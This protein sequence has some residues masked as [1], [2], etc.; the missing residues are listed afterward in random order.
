MQYYCGGENANCKETVG[1][2]PRKVKSLSY[3]C[4]CLVRFY[5]VAVRGNRKIDWTKVDYLS[6]VDFVN[7]GRYIIP[8]SKLTDEDKAF[9]SKSGVFRTTYTSV[10]QYILSRWMA[11]RTKQW[12]YRF[13]CNLSENTTQA[14][15]LVIPSACIVEIQ[16]F[17]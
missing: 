13:N 17:K 1:R 8:V 9:V 10:D 16:Y 3:L 4:I 14:S 11:E 2:H 5:R 7:P 12:R 6:V 15:A